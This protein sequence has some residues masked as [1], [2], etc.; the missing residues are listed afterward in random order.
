LR[1]W[2]VLS[3][4]KSASTISTGVG[5]SFTCFPFTTIPES[6]P[7]ISIKSATK[8]RP[9]SMHTTWPSI[10]LFHF[11]R[12]AAIGKSEYGSC[13][14]PITIAVTLQER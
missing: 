10:T 7:A 4:F 9:R 11:W 1:D 8:V 14:S 5:K 12:Q 13:C 3:L 2:V 6:F